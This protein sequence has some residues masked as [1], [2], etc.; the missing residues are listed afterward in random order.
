VLLDQ[1]KLNDGLLVDPDPSASR[2]YG[3]DFAALAQ[4]LLALLGSW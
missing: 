1:D 3:A 2:R 4:S